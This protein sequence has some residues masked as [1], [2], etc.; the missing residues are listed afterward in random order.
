MNPTYF[1]KAI[2][3]FTN[4]KLH[5]CG[6]AFFLIYTIFVVHSGFKHN[7]IVNSYPILIHQRQYKIIIILMIDLT[8]FISSLHSVFLRRI[9]LPEC[10]V[11]LLVPV[12]Y[13]LFCFLKCYHPGTYLLMKESS[14]L[15]KI[16][17]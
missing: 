5:F 6:W 3:S 7:I 4:I 1:F 17:F 16:H 15:Y 2:L 9:N 12:T 11:T 13:I 8:A 10:S 14:F